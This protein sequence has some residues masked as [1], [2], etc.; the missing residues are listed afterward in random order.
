[1]LDSALRRSVSCC[2]LN[3][4]GEIPDR[5][6]F[7]PYR[8]GVHIYD[9]AGCSLFLERFGFFTLRWFRN[10]PASSQLDGTYTLISRLAH[11]VVKAGLRKRTLVTV[12]YPVT[13]LIGWAPAPVPPAEF[14]V[15]K[16]VRDGVC[17]MPSSV[18]HESGTCSES[19]T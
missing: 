16:A 13:L 14:V 2:R 4:D 12:V 6:V 8:A 3:L 17:L 9:Y 11:Q 19:P 1:V 10:T 18:H 7:S 5:Q 15:V